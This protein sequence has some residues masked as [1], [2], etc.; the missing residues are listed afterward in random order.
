MSY[1][2]QPVAGATK[3]ATIAYQSKYYQ[4]LENLLDAAFGADRLLKSSYKLRESSVKIDELSKLKI[5]TNIDGQEVLLASIAY[6]Q[7]QMGSQKALLLGPLAVS[8]NCQGKGYGQAIM[9]DTIAKAKTLAKIKGWQ[10][11]ILIG[12]LDYYTK[13]GFKRVPMGTIDYPNPVDE[14][15]ILYLNLQEDGLKNT[16]N[17]QPLPLKIN[18]L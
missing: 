14:A 3:I 13:I 7:L 18:Q 11:I 15:R 5:E 2:E 10:F 9:A 12:D 16:I 6:Y 17:H 4:Q 8:P 1:L